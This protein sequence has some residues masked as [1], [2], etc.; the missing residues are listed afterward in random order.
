MTIA[1]PA[2]HVWL[3]SLERAGYTA[4]ATNIGGHCMQPRAVVPIRYG[5]NNE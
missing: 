2:K 4:L 1:R 5:K 3:V